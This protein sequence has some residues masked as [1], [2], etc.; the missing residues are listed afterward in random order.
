[1]SAGYLLDT[2]VVSELRK[3]TRCDLNV[4]RWHESL[5]TDSQWLSVLVL[6]E[7]RHGV[8]KLRSKDPVSSAHLEKWLEGLAKGYTDRILPITTE[9]ADRWGT[10]CTGNPLPYVDGLLCATAIEHNLTLATRNVKDVSRSGVSFV[11]PF[12]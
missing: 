7:I 11:N 2:N 10:L 3:G 4:K 9:I 1:M 5:N 6:G 8:E 12:D